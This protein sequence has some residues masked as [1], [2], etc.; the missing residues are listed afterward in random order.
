[1]Q[2][3]YRYLQV[4]KYKGLVFNSPKKLVVDCYADTYFLG[5]CRH[6]TLNTIFVIVLGICLWSIFLISLYCVFQNYRQ[7][8]LSL[9]YTISMWHFLTMLDSYFHQIFFIKEVIENLGIDSDKLNFVSRSTVYEDNN[10]SIVV[11][12][13]PR[14]TPTPKHIAVKY[15]YFRQ[16][17]G[18]EFLIWKIEPEIIRQICSPK[19]YK[20]DYFSG[21]GSFYVVGK[22]SY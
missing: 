1:M 11:T 2:S 19:V 13:S 16:H 3:I 7:R 17:V 21:L 6:E 5:L 9:L 12:T 10:G 4:I 15:H 22:P 14:M 8:F 20:V 18:K